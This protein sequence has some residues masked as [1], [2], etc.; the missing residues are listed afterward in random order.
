MRLAYRQK[1]PSVSV[2]GKPG[3]K[4]SAVPEGSAREA[5][6]G[7]ISRKKLSL[8]APGVCPEEEG[9]GR[10]SVG[11]AA[12]HPQADRRSPS[13]P[14]WK[15]VA[16]GM[17]G[18]SGTQASRG[19]EGFCLVG[20]LPSSDLPST[21]RLPFMAF[22]LGDGAGA[23][24]VPWTDPWYQLQTPCQPCL[25]PAPLHPWAFDRRSS[26]AFTRCQLHALGQVIPSAAWNRHL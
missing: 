16:Q 20:L 9:S 1:N 18:V 15:T 13:P 6:P 23:P 14:C 5:C 26:K 17:D 25:L 10:V 2:Q 8:P 21:S 7:L 11:E 12:P 22:R 4:S 24:E 3:S 19:A